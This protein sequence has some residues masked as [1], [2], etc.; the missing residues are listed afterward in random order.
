MDRELAPALLHRQIQVLAKLLRAIETMDAGQLKGRVGLFDDDRVFADGD[1]GDLA[2]R[3]FDLRGRN[4]LVRALDAW[5]AAAHQLRGAQTG[6]HD[7]LERIGAVR[8]LNHETC[9]FL[10]ALVRLGLE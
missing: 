4:H 1:A 8:T 3:D 5:D 6:N 2:G 9:F 10:A 7:E